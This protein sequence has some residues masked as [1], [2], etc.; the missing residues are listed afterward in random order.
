MLRR[1]LVGSV[2]ALLVVCTVQDGVPEV[3]ED[4]SIGYDAK[5]Y[6]DGL[7]TA[8]FAPVL[9]RQLRRFMPEPDSSIVDVGCGNGL[10]VSALR[11]TGQTA[12]CLEGSSEAKGMWPERFL[13]YYHI[14]DLTSKAA[15]D[16]MPTTDYVSTFEV[17]EHLAPEHADRFVALLTKHKPKLVFFGAATEFQDRG[18]NPTH[19]N[20]NSFAYWV[21]KFKEVGYAL[22]LVKSATLR[23]QLLADETL[24]K[25]FARAWWWPKNMLVFASLEHTSQAVLDAERQQLPAHIDMLSDSYTKLGYGLSKEFGEMWERDWKEFGH[26]FHAHDARTKQEL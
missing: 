12:Y 8:D 21:A 19:V 18:Q 6:E 16:I 11:D 10:L 4:G 25:R 23:H 9:A 1:V 2:L 15:T 26:L 13:S 7:K 24:Q 5:F 14:V 3:A 20:E 22:D 17:A